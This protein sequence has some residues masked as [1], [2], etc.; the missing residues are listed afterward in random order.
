MMRQSL[1]RRM[2]QAS[3]DEIEAALNAWLRERPGAEHGDA[4]GRHVLAEELERLLG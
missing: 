3:S 1:R 2:P 4:A